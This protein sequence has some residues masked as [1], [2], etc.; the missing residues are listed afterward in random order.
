MGK[1]PEWTNS[2]VF[3]YLADISS[4]NKCWFYHEYV[5]PFQSNPTLQKHSEH[6][7]SWFYL[8]LT[9]HID[10]CKRLNNLKTSYKCWFCTQAVRML[11]QMTT[12]GSCLMKDIHCTREIQYIHCWGKIQYMLSKELHTVTLNLHSKWQITILLHGYKKVTC[13]EVHH[14]SIH[15][16][17]GQQSNRYKRCSTTIHYIYN[18]P[19]HTK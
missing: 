19:V 9:V 18:D 3:T 1:P 7:L 17:P 10:L 13:S 11:F 5:S 4:F 16:L 12:S 2:T 8:D 14:H 15:N 6:C